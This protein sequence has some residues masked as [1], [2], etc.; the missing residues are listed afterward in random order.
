MQR[1]LADHVTEITL[2][3]Q[4]VLRASR[5][6]DEGK[7][8]SNV[9]SMLK[10]NSCGKALQIARECRDMLVRLTDPSHSIFEILGFGTLFLHA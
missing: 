7:L 5:L 8:H 1:K 3:L 6:R 9:V 2:A 4:A 10:R